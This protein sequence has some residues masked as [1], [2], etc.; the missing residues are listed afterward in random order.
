MIPVRGNVVSE[1]YLET[2]G[3]PIL[4]GRGFQKSDDGAASRVAIVSRSLAD[5]LWPGVDPIGQTFLSL[6]RL[7]VVGSCRTRF[8]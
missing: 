6:T 7:E 4:R 5:R 8:I 3:I 1:R 2:M